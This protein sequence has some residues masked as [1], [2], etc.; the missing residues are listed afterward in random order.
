[1]G[2]GTLMALIVQSVTLP[3]LSVNRVREP[4]VHGGKARPKS[5]SLII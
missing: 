1:M 5:A 3:S 2:G 4:S